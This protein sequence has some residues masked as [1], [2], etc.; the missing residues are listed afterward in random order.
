[1]RHRP[2]RRQFLKQ[3]AAALAGFAVGCG[4]N[5]LPPSSRFGIGIIGVGG[6]GTNAHLASLLERG[7]VEVLA[8]ADVEARNVEGARSRSS[9]IDGYR[10]YRE[11]LARSDI[12][13]VVVATPD[14]WHV[15][16]SIAAANAGKH[17]YCEK[18]LTLTVAEGRTLVDAVRA[19]GIAFQTGSQQ[20]STEEFQLAC[21]IARNGVLGDLVRVETRFARGPTMAVVSADPQPDT[22]D[23]DT[24]LGPAPAVA[25]HQLRAGATF[26]YFRD[27]SGGTITDLGAH[28]LD[29][30]QW[31]SGHDGS[32]PV[33]VS[34]TATFDPGM[35]ETPVTFAVDFAYE[36][37]LTVHMTDT[38]GEWFV[39]F[40]GTD[41]D[42]SVHRGGIEASRPELLDY[43]LGS[44]A[45][46]LETSRDHYGNWLDAIDSGTLPI[47]DVEIGHRGAT[48]CHLANI[49]IE[50][51]RAL[52]WDPVAEQFVGDTEA[53]ALL[54]RS[55]R[56]GWG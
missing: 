42:V 18:P 45:V 10:D 19:N 14:H 39:Q 40:F 9:R 53:D 8:V 11:L 27:Y 52:T 36:G 22:L 55:P 37:G 35:Y 2:A 15:P 20:R 5:K 26:R 25:Y 49:A 47:C 41:G 4:D 48:M 1:M 54:S 29:I 24:W 46:V 6:F 43:Q 50:T 56:D 33:S 30:V 17:V 12:D 21:E 38:D 32:G 31:G 34:G 51:G 3:S 7:D 16:V 23:W 44:G 28:E 13:A